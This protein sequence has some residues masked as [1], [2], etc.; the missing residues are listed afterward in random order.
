M[1][2]TNSGYQR[3]TKLTISVEL[4]GVVQSTNIFPLLESFTYNSVTYPAVTTTQIQQM[5]NDDYTN[6]VTAYAAYVQANNQSQYPGLVV[7]SAGSRVYNDSA[8][9][10]I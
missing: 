4:N 8:C 9:P 2:Y 7:T 3:A 5:T 1:R 10:I 6:R